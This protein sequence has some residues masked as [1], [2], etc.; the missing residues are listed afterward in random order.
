MGCYRVAKRGGVDIL[1]NEANFKETPNFV[2]YS[3]GERLLGNVGQSK[4]V[5]NF[6]NTVSNFNRLLGISANHPDLK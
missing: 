5:T 2:S 6:R 1:D 3:T 4:A